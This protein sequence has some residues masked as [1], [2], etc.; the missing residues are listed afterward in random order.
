MRNDNRKS[1]SPY[2]ELFDHGTWGGAWGGDYLLEAQKVEGYFQFWRKTHIFKATGGA[3][4]RLFLAYM[5]GRSTH[6]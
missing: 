2:R 1:L 4:K 3:P 5:G 6:L